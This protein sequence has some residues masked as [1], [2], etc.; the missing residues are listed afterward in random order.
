MQ[1]SADFYLMLGLDPGATAREIARAYRVLIRQYHPDTA[2]TP[3]RP[4]QGVLQ[5]DRLVQIMEAHHVL[6]DPAR[7]ERYDRGRQLATVPAH[8]MQA[9]GAA[10]VGLSLKI[11]PLRWEPPVRRWI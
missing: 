7:R 8:D 3:A 10:G 11:S 5:V 9:N 2:A 4:G 6:S 1:G